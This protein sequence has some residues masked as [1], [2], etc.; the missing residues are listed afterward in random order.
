MKSTVAKTEFLNMFGSVKQQQA[1][2]HTNIQIDEEILHEIVGQRSA[3]VDCGPPIPDKLATIA[4]KCLE[5]YSKN[6]N[7]LKKIKQ[8]LK[9]PKNC[10]KLGVKTLNCDVYKNNNIL[11]YYKQNY[12][13][14]KDVL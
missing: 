11:P 3:S 10:P 5:K 4:I 7:L 13:K 14:C 2:N 9:V 1:I 6:K 12:K 8:N